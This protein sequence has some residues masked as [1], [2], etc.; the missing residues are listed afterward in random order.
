MESHNL[1]FMP[2]DQEHPL[3]RYAPESSHPE[4]LDI[5]TASFPTSASLSL[6]FSCPNRHPLHFSHLIS[7][8]SKNNTWKSSSVKVNRSFALNHIWRKI[9]PSIKRTLSTGDAAGFWCC[10]SSSRRHTCS[11]ICMA[12][13]V[14]WPLRMV[15]YYFKMLPLKTRS[16]FSLFPPLVLQKA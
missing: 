14:V 10:S 3:P 5:L 16:F 9:W 15:L 1:S 6:A 4:E 8:Y 13:S 12:I 2:K 7:V 11:W